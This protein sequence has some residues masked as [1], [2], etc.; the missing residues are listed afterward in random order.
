MLIETG[1]GTL[2]GLHDLGPQFRPNGGVLRDDGCWG[3]CKGYK[4]E[5][6]LNVGLEVGQ[7]VYIYIYV[8]VF[9]CIY[10]YT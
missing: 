6:K 4:G 9:M 5:L 3:Q 1:Q 2:Q 8:Y 7:V 10:I